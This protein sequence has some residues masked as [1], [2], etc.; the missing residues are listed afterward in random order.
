MP[1][2][3]RWLLLGIVLATPQVPEIQGLSIMATGGQVLVSFRFEGGMTEEIRERIDSGL[4]TSFVYELELMKDRKHWWDR[5]LKSS[6]VEVVA[7]YN[8]VTHEY[9]LNTKHDGR[10]IGS[11]TVREVD[12]LERAM[13]RFASFPAFAVEAGAEPG[14]YLVRARVEL[15]L[16][17]MLGFIPYQRDTPWR[18]SNKIRFTPA[19]P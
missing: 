1:W 3:S 15:G 10:L 19:A 4:P 9:L 13:T 14:R 8:A 6:R 5:P 12:E 17:A 11:Q 7:M 18:E 16:G 2:L